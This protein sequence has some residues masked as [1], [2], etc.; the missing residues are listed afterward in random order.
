MRKIEICLSP[1]L[2]HL[3]EIKNKNVVIVDIFRATSTMVTALAKGVDH[4]ISVKELEDCLSK[5]AKGYLTAGEREGKTA[6]GFDL[7]NSPVAFLKNDYK[8][9]KLA[10]TTTN[11]T[12]A[13]EKVKKEAARVFIGAFLNLNATAEKLKQLPEDVLILCA[14]W[15][16]KFN[17]EDS[18]YAGG[19]VSTLIPAFKTECDSSIAMRVLYEQ[20]RNDLKR[21]LAQ[22]SHTKRLQ[23][24]NIEEDITHCLSTDLYKGMIA[25]MEGKKI[26]AQQL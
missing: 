25:I 9:K 3:Y 16:G 4:I 1:D 12:V 14:G 6:E 8:G 23:N 5:K 21:I 24:Q 15:K 11:G 7:G 26:V 10:L 22:A 19:L 13:I 18:L 17:L 20:Y 2:L